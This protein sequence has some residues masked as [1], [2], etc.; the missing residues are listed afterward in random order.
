MKKLILFFLCCLVVASIKAQFSVKI[1][2]TDVAT[3]A[4]EDIYVAGNFNSWNPKL[5]NY[6][7]KQFGAG[8]RQIVLKDVEAGRYE[9]KLTRGD[10]SKV[11]CTAEGNDIPN[12]TIDVNGDVTVEIKV[13]GW[14]DD[15]PVKPKPYT[16][17]PQVKII[18]TAFKMP[19][20]NRTRRIWVYLPKGYSSSTK[21][22][23]VVYMNDG[24]NLFNE[25]TAP[26]G[27]WGVDECLD[28]LQTKYNKECIIV[29]IDNSTEKRMTEYNPYDDAKFGKGE[30]KQYI[31]FIVKT[32]KPFV[33]SKYRTKKDVANTSIVGSSMGGLISWYGITQYP[34][35]FGA[36]GIFSPS[37]WLTPQAYLDAAATDWDAALK[38]RLFFYAGGK[39]SATMV[40]DTKRMAAE[41]G[42]KHA[43]SQVTTLIAPLGQHNE[44][45]WREELPVF[46]K[47]LLQ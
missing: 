4:L 47:W 14:R 39:E 8:R 40:D 42:K 43:S 1:I 32:L 5:D 12:R 24:Q 30:G 22:Y 17:L 25:Q 33:D 44:K 36:A 41:V 15:Y 27:E 26:F 7:L 46:F 2:V 28:S 38:P 3:K 6:K 16:A 19:E 37:F 31:E 18:D 13:A 34:N 29:G 20:L 10:F 11:E 45:A 21:T 23:P 35:V 9:F